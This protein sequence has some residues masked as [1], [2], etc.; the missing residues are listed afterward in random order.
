VT[1]LWD[2]PS[3]VSARALKGAVDASRKQDLPVP[4]AEVVL[5]DPVPTGRVAAP[6]GGAGA[7]ETV[8]RPSRKSHRRANLSLAS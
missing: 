2:S 6:A 7:G 8:R 1:R 5:A 4:G 3:E